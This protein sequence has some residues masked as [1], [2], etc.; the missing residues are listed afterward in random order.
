[1]DFERTKNSKRNIL[2]GILNR[3]VLLVCPFV[4]RTVMIYV[5]GTE[6]VGLGNLFNSIIQILSLSELGIGSALVYFMYKPISEND[7]EKVN[8][9]LNFYKK[10]YYVIGVVILLAGIV[11]TPC[12]KFLINGDY[13]TDINIYGLYL[14]YIA[15]TCAGYFFW[16]YKRSILYAGQHTDIESKVSTVFTIIQYVL[17][18]SILFITK[19]YYVYIIVLPMTTIISNI[20]LGRV[21]DKKY[22]QYYAKG[23]IDRDTFQLVKSK[24]G[25]IVLQKIGTAVLTS[26]DNIVIS[27]FLGLKILT[28]YNN[29][30]FVI[31]ALFSVLNVI[32]LSIIPSIGNS[33][34]VESRKKNW[35]DFQKFN[36]LYNFVISW[37]VTCLFVLYQPFMRLWMGDKLG[38]NALLRNDIVALLC[39]Y[40]FVLKLGDIV[41]AYNEA[42]GLWEKRKF[43]NIIAS[44]LNLVLNIVLVNQIGLYGILISTIV[45]VIFVSI[46]ADS[47]VL[48]KYYFNDTQKWKLFIAKQFY[49]FLIAAIGTSVISLIC[50]YELKS[51]FAN[52]FIKASIV[53]VLS[54]VFYTVA[55]YKNVQFKKCCK[56]IKYSLVRRK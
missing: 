1:M 50:S 26:V 13:P 15:N 51:S 52:F 46:P 16:G 48:F 35:G 39:V 23:K 28:I 55:Y 30:V 8:R 18:I 22:P 33:I 14:I 11:T 40:F 34:V 21:V 43:I 45:S 31:T 37:A 12:I 54:L 19:N 20:V 56:F 47:Y 38:S 53:C 32:L 41:H 17:Q 27:A 36:F 9:L 6:Y 5:M 2:W 24:V 29:Y 49:H 3:L 4:L 25:G 44:L 10:S 42:C 7:I